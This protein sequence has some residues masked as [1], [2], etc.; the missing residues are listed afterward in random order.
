[1]LLTFPAATTPT[2]KLAAVLATLIQAYQSLRVRVFAHYFLPMRSAREMTSALLEYVYMGLLEIA[3]DS[4]KEV[5][6]LAHLSAGLVELADSINFRAA[7]EDTAHYL[8]VEHV[9]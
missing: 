1:L 5:N 7:R 2:A 6:A 9:I 3:T 4:H 8:Q